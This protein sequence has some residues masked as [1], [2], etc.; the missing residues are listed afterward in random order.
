MFNKYLK[1]TL[2]GLCLC[3]SKSFG[4]IIQKDMPQKVVQTLGYKGKYM[5]ADVSRKISF[6]NNLP[7]I[8]A[9]FSQAMPVLRS[10]L[11]R[12]SQKLKEPFKIPAEYTTENITFAFKNKTFLNGTGFK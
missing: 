9:S 1:F 11:M 6:D 4:G 12:V 3:S 5:Q 7:Q 2:T 8:I 10:D